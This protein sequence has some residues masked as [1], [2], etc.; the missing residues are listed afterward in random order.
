MNSA[1]YVLYALMAGGLLAV[2]AMDPIRVRAIRRLAEKLSMSYCSDVSA[3][4]EVS[5]TGTE[6]EGATLAW[7]VIS[8]VRNG[9]NVVAFDCR[10]GK[11]KGSW[12]RTVI[13]AETEHN[14]FGGAAFLPELT[15]ATSGKW[16]LLYRQR[17]LEFL[18]RGLM[19]VKELEAHIESIKP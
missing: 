17:E 2:I 19:P 8:G 7:N 14:V 13:A 18:A 3:F 9:I 12:R 10:I 1:A 15:V 6:L 5:L 4:P 16:K 11:G